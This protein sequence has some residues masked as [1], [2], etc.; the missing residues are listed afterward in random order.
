MYEAQF[1]GVTNGMLNQPPELFDVNVVSDV[2]ESLM[3]GAVI[4]PSDLVARNLHRGR[5]HGLPGY[6]EYRYETY[7][8]MQM[9]WLVNKSLF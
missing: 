1:E 9:S 7:F 4:S 3:D 6:N 2:T 5:D 8:H